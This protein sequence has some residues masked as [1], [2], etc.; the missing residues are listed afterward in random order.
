MRQLVTLVG[1]ASLAA[2]GNA[3]DI[4]GTWSIV[5]TID[6][7]SV[8][9]LLYGVALIDASTGLA[10]GNWNS[11][12]GVWPLVQRWDGAA[13][14]ELALPST[15]SLG[16]LPKTEGVDAHGQHMWVVG[17]VVTGYPTNNMPLIMRWNGQ[18]WMEAATP[19]L[20]A[21]NTYPFGPRGGYAYDV[22]AIDSDDVW[23]VGGAAGYGD[24]SA[25]SVPLALHFDGSDWSDIPVPQI[26]TRSHSLE[27]VSASDSDNVWAVG[28]WRSIAQNYQALIVRWDGSQWHLVPNPGE[29]PSGGDAQCVAAIEH[30]DVWVSG[31]FNG[32][33]DHLIHWNGA[34]W[35]TADV[36]LP[37]PFA[38]MVAIAPDDIWGSCAINATYY[39]FDG[40]TWTPAAS[41]NIAGAA[42]V[43]RGWAMATAGPCDVWSVGGWSDG[44]VQRSLSEHLTSSTCLADWNADQH[45]DFF[46]VQA[47]LTAFAAFDASA[48]LNDDEMHD[49]FDLQAFL[50]LFATG[51]P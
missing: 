32:G 38:D 42:Y 28:H 9:N 27:H 8:T 40:H 6:R 11:G 30:N 16:S 23:V 31:S 2:V 33:A 17:S 14:T 18:S 48:D 22:V 20:R 15:A 39:H 19:T 46:D 44:M 13:W 47:F 24:A 10:V 4:C 51:C 45:L 25:T 35:D 12:A 36:D 43:L 7:G 37:G 50:A 3:Q 41:P 29:G 26:G 5:P 21:Q 1:L 34:S 49:F